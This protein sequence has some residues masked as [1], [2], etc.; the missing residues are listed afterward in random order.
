MMNRLEWGAPMVRRGAPFVGHALSSRAALGSGGAAHSPSPR[1]H[2]SQE[3]V[4]E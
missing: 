4:T 2:S 1:G 3:G